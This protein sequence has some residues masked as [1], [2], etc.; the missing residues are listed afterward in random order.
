MQ[1]KKVLIVTYY[2]IPSGGAGVQRWVKFTKYLR[3]FGWE[4][5]IYTPENPEYPSI[6]HSFEKDIPNDIEILKTPIWE[7]YNVYRNLTGKKNKAINAGFIS[8]DKKQSWKDKISIR[9]RG[10]FLIPDPRR[11]W[12]KPS[13]RFLTDFLKKNPVDAVITT[14]PPHSMHMIGLGLKKNF[15]NL[16]WVADFR[17]PWTNI[18]FYKELN[19]TGLADKIH[20]RLEKEIVQKADNVVVVSNGMK[21]EY[22]LLKPQKIDV[23][24][25]GYDTADEQKNDIKLD[26]KFTVS[27]I[28]TLNAARN[29]QTVWKVLSEICS[30]NSE[31]K[32][33]LQ[34]QLVGKV[35]F[36]VLE[37]IRNN[38]LEDQLLKIDYLSHS[39]AIAK[40]ESSQV[41]LLLINNSGNAKGIL[42]GKFYEYLAA[43]R[44]ILGVGPTDGD[45]AQV[46]HETGGGVMVGFSDEI[47]TKKVILDYYKLYKSNSLIIKTESVEKYSRKSLTEQLAILLNLL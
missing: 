11:F 39:E 12:I 19:L 38:G 1:M 37:D 45:A 42:T 14:G 44:P 13:V 40:Q 33:D 10:N 29:P 21:I 22:E 4:P 27:H 20:H 34:I 47:A 8:E 24:S 23:I 43:K 17:D 32:S 5:I 46:L 7:P 18:D 15:P 3:D 30:D 26:E 25:N 2:W 35:D 28:G 41:L 6:D 31:F 9:I 16:P 36:S